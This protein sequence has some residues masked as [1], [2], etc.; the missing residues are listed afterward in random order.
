MKN[1]LVMRERIKRWSF[2]KCAVVTS[3]WCIYGLN[4]LEAPR[5]LNTDACDS[6][7]KVSCP[8]NWRRTEKH[9]RP[10]LITRNLLTFNPGLS[11]AVLS[12]SRNVFA[13]NGRRV[14]KLFVRRG[15]AKPFESVSVVWRFSSTR[16]PSHACRRRAAR[17]HFVF[18]SVR[19][20]KIQVHLW[21]FYIWCSFVTKKTKRVTPLGFSKS[22]W[23]RSRDFI[24]R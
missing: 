5:K 20:A 22:F 24:C 7:A 17:S 16:V 13:V 2:V 12:W 4:R 15:F 1:K 21:V 23:H 9:V 14:S 8:V 18:V 3:Y 10:S 6:S 11:V 19:K